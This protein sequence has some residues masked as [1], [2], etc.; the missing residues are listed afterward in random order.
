MFE[1]LRIEFDLTPLAQVVAWGKPG[2]QSLHWFGLT[3]G[4]YDVVIG[5]HRLFSEH[6]R[7]DGIDYQ[8]VRLWEDLI[9]LLPEILDEVP[10]ALATRLADV[11]A[12]MAWNDRAWDLTEELG[13][14]PEL[15]DA[16]TCWWRDRR[17]DTGHLVAAPRLQLWRTSG[18]VHATWRTRL[19]EH[20]VARAD[21]PRWASPAGDAELALTELTDEI[22]RFDHA[23]I[24]AMQAR[25]DEVAT[26][27]SRP[28]V[29][30]DVEQL[31]RE[32][33]DRSGW[34]T[35]TLARVHRTKRPWDE[36]VTAI[37]TLENHIGRVR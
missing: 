32:H 12:W 17:L 31:R 16:A 9:D 15:L 37:T 35:D 25:V 18:V 28:D 23:L 2:N 30:I 3:D 14:D 27:W 13:L 34:L 24:A 10:D 6:D 29:A 21:L 19:G 1:S 4:R 5:E 20:E 33:R 36:V 7:M 22:R 11:D 26:S 8:V